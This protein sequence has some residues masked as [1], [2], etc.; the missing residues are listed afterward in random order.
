ML[1]PTLTQEEIPSKLRD[2]RPNPAYPQDL[3]C[4]SGHLAPAG[5]RFF[6]VS[7]SC[8]PPGVAGIY[9]EPCLIV[10]NTRI[11][12]KKE[13]IESRLEPHDELAMELA[14]AER[15]QHGRD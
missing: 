1:R 9:C 2:G 12:R 3:H 7:G 11:R 13:G 14:K 4:K 15:K 6:R 10:V 8:V 5:T